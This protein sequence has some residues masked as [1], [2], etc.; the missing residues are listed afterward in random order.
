MSDKVKFVLFKNKKKERENQPDMT[1]NIEDKDGNKTHYLSGWF[2]V[3]N[4]GG[5]KFISGELTSVAEQM[6][7]KKES[8]T[9]TTPPVFEKAVEKENDLPV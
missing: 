4:A 6:Q 8:S 5:D 2:R 9:A 3:P 7:Y 1:G